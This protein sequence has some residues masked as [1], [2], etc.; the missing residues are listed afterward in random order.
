MRAIH[1]L[2]AMLEYLGGQR[3]D[4]PRGFPLALRSLAWGLGWGVL[5]CMIALFSGQTT[6]FIYIVF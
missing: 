6:R 1:R 5:L 4:A 2:K 3:D